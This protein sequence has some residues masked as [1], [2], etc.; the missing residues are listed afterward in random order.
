MKRKQRLR[1]DRDA[2]RQRAHYKTDRRKVTAY[3]VT[4]HHV[5]PY[6]FLDVVVPR[7]TR[8]FSKPIV[9]RSR[10]HSSV[11]HS[12]VSGL[13]RPDFRLPPRPKICRYVLADRARRHAQ[14]RARAKGG[15]AR[16]EHNRKHDRRC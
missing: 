7:E 9:L 5:S 3:P 12:S 16:P 6:R 8:I 10:R 15:S 13:K 1:H 2:L 11:T 4:Y 14:F